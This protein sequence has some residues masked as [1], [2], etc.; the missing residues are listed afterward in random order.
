VWYFVSD[1]LKDPERLRADLERVVEHERRSM[2]GDPELEATAWVDKLAEVERKRGG[3]QDMAAEELITL[4]ELRGKLAGLE[5]TRRIAE[6]ELEVLRGHRE[7]LEALERDKEAVVET[8]ARMASEAL[9]S[10]AP[11][12][13]HQFYQM[14]RLRVEVQPDGTT[15]VGGAFNEE[16]EACT[17]ETTS[18][19]CGLSTHR[20]GLLKFSIRLSGSDRPELELAFVD[21]VGLYK[22]LTTCLS[23]LVATKI[24]HL[25]DA[26]DP[27]CL[28]Q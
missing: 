28:L 13:R 10:L 23:Q 27:S 16:L 2:R 5:E 22:P 17:L 15:E 7:A 1:V 14:L 8:Y 20:S 21:N 12:K 3:F 9:N 25:S 19:C 24:T 18:R 26:S 11:E 4:D 6:R